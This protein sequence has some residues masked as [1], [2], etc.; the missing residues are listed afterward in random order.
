M[1]IL[2][3]ISNENEFYSQ[4]F[5]DENF[6]GEVASAA[7]EENEREEASRAQYEEAKAKGLPAPT[8]FRPVW[9]QL[10]ALARDEPRR[11]AEASRIK[12][13]GLRVKEEKKGI[14]A[15]IAAL[16]LPANERELTLTSGLRLPLL[17]EKLDAA[18]DPYLWIFEATAAGGAG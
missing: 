11:M 4:H 10:S 1:A 6:A 13:G 8:L 17:G 16:G 9:K 2:A 14:L 7:R 5:L 18:G 12:N 3:G 15:L